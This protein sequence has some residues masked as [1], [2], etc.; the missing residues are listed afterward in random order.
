MSQLPNYREKRSELF[1]GKAQ[2]MTNRYKFADAWTAF[3]FFRLEGVR[4][5][6][7]A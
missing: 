4:G 5:K 1:S 3:D 7:S 2:E 6:Q